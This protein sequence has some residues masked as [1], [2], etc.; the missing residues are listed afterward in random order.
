LESDDLG[1]V[2]PETS[3][4]VQSAATLL[5]R[6]GFTVEPHPLRGIEPALELWW[7]FFGPVIAHIHSESLPDNRESLS[8]I[9]RDYLSA[10]LRQSP[11]SLDEFMAACAQRDL[12]RADLLGQMQDVTILLSPVSS[13]PAFRHDHGTWRSPAGYRETMRASQWL[14]L[15]GFPGISVPFGSSPDGLPIG[16]QIIGRPYEDELLLAVAE[17]LENARGPWQPPPDSLPQND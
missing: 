7:F 8:P 1:E 6:S 12:L 3:A 5:A 9:F 10:A 16:V 4:A 13:A 17:V 14:N 15:A 11:I 2:T